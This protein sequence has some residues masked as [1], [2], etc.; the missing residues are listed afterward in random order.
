MQVY[1]RLTRA[2]AQGDRVGVCVT[3]LDAKSLERGI[4]C[5]YGHVTLVSNILVSVRQIRFFKA[6]CKTGAKF[7]FT[8][9]HTTGRVT[10]RVRVRVRVKMREGLRVRVRV[11]VK[12]REGLRVR[13]RVRARVRVGVKREREGG[14]EGEGEGEGE[15]G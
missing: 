14:G 1:K 2:I 6:A 5:T 15:R 12:M 8:V 7:H 13:V 9:G 11:R 3:Q 4:A 10:V